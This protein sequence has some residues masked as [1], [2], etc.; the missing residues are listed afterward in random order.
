[1]RYGIEVV[2]LGDYADPRPV[3][4]LAVAAEEA[5]WDGLFVWDHL[6]FAWGVPSADPWVVLAAVAQ[7]TGRLR[8]GTT[9]TPLAR[10]RP[11]VIANAVAT[12]DLLSEGRVVLGAGLGGV[13]EE[14]T[15]FGEPGDARQRARRLDEGLEVLRRL[16]QG[17]PVTHHGDHYRVEGVTLAPLPLQRPRVP[18]WIG[19]DS[20]AALRRAARWDGWATAG[21]DQEGRPTT[22][23]ERVAAQLQEIRRHRT[24]EGA[25]DVALT[26]RSD[27]GDT[28]AAAA[29][30]EAGVT[31]WLES[32]HGFRGP[33]QQ[34]RE[35]VAAGPPR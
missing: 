32:L 11:Q 5:G 23:P 1:M 26:G 9:V 31:W 34:L 10:R 21:V 8:V 27:P 3:V 4:D 7:A 35:R 17:R 12:L 16:W 22:T 13:P 24:T 25:F 29:F 28:A 15:A 6:G 2:T 20:P 30:G 14:F 19:G 18:V 33:F